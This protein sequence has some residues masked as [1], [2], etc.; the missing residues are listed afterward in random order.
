MSVWVIDFQTS[1]KMKDKKQKKS[2]WHNLY[3]NCH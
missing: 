3:E 1:D 2:V